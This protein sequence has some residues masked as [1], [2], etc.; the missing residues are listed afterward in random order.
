VAGL[1]KHFV[2]LRW[3]PG[4]DLTRH[5]FL[6]H[7][8]PPTLFFPSCQPVSL[9]APGQFLSDYQTPPHADP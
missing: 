6:A 4:L 7:F 5:W 1:A 3:K 9:R 8:A 2:T